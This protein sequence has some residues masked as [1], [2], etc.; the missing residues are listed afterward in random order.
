MSL[1][2]FNILDSFTYDAFIEFHICVVICSIFVACVDV[3]SALL[4]CK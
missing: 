3:T 1:V 4:A 2:H